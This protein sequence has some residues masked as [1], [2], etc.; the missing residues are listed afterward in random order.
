MT[1]ATNSP[2][3]DLATKVRT[4]HEAATAAAR[5]ALDHA[6][7]CGDALIE[8]KSWVPHGAWGEWLKQTGISKRTAQLYMR[9]AR[10][11]DAL[12]SA[13]VAHLTIR[14]AVEHISRLSAK[15]KP[16]PRDPMAEMKAYAEAAQAHFEITEWANFE[17]WC[18]WA[19]IAEHYRN[20]L[21]WLI[22]DW[23]N[24]GKARYGPRVDKDLKSADCSKASVH[25]IKQMGATA[26]A[27]PPERRRTA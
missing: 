14:A 11:R 2:L 17:E 22:G 16:F 8:A 7:D 21:P 13:T 12:K 24:F 18:A 19:R 4:H 6:L 26:K 1:D 25:E 27:F 20:E 23:Y 5:T 15:P 9:L 3:Q 10:N